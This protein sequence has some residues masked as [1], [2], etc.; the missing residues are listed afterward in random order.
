MLRLLGSDMAQTVAKPTVL[1]TEVPYPPSW[2]DR[3][4]AWVEDLPGPAWLFYSLS[5]LAMA[6]LINAVFWI[7]GSAPAG[8]IDPVNTSFA[9]F[10]VY[11]PV[12]YRYLT[13][14]G[15]RALRT[16]R[17]LLDA[18]DG[19]IVRID[20]ELATLPRS[21]GWLAIPLGFGFAILTIL[22]DPA[23][24][25]DLVPR[26][27]L[28]YVGDIVVTGFMVSMFYCL[29]IRSIRQLRMVAKLHARATKVN[30]L[31]LE[32]AHA[33]SDLTARTGIGVILVLIGGYVTDPLA[34][35][36]ALDILISLI[37]VLVA[38]GIFILPIMGIQDRIE[39]EKKRVLRR[40][41]D[42]LETATDRLHD[43]V[44]SNS[45][46]DMSETNHAI[47][48][49]MRERELIKS[50]STWPW[51]PRTI[52]NFASALLLPIFLWLVTRLLEGVF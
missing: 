29:L 45:Y 2:F 52:R 33:F 27:A 47:E 16:F 22:G 41:H 14:V 21:S 19:E 35:G 46:T 15:S 34:F 31:E 39:E 42:L 6:L 51:D 13:G 17:P 11:W 28:P 26:T 24:Y 9:I 36:S 8:T 4:I 25:G 12:L 7:D 23:P 10:V 32:P 1:G 3:L 20:Y 49:L 37:T 18:D 44:R 5:T 43:Q 30:L 38:V 50:V 40:T 48:A